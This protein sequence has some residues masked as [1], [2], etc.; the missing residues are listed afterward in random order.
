MGNST[1]WLTDIDEFV[2]A[3][4]LHAG[5]VEA[6]LVTEALSED[7][8]AAT[9]GRELAGAEGIE[10]MAGRRAESQVRRGE[11]L[12]PVATSLEAFQ[13]PSMERLVAFED[14][15]RAE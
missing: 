4:E 9:A 14:V 3:E 8:E 12:C 7:L 11:Q 6:R 13:E 1:T 15:N 2:L 5:R 10:G